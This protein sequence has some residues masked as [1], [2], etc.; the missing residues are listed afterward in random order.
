MGCEF[1]DPDNSLV[2][3]ENEFLEGNGTL[4][5]PFLIYSSSDFHN[6]KYT[7]YGHYQLMNDIDFITSPLILDNGIVLEGMSMVYVPFY[8]SLDGNGHELKYSTTEPVFSKLSGATIKN[9]IFNVNYD[10]EKME[11]DY[12]YYENIEKCTDNDYCR[13]GYDAVNRVEHKSYG[14]IALVADESTLIDN[15]K[16]KGNAAKRLDNRSES[17]YDD[18]K[19][20]VGLVVGENYGTINNIEIDGIF[21]IHLNKQIGQSFFTSENWEY[22]VGGAV[23]KNAGIMEN[24]VYNGE[25]N[26]I[27]NYKDFN[28]VHGGLVGSNEGDLTGGFFK[29]KLY[30]YNYYASGISAYGNSYSGGVIGINEVSGDLENAW[31][32]GEIVNKTADLAYVG[33]ITALNE[34]AING[35]IAYFSYEVFRQW[36]DLSNDKTPGG[37]ICR[38]SNVNISNSYYIYQDSNDKIRVFGSKLEDDENLRVLVSDLDSILSKSHFNDDSWMLSESMLLPVYKMETSYWSLYSLLI[39]NTVEEN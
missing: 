14:L 5:D 25:Y 34:G 28:V 31:F 6:I 9:V 20:Y 16:I 7:P 21:T 30:T 11:S 32:D 2:P 27:S 13:F 35:T 19:G 4:D 29:G 8:G 23:G 3:I 17:F 22:Y 10:E 38:G 15:V 12:S 37:L 24:V 18:D 36:S 26:L 1:L 39:D 33:G